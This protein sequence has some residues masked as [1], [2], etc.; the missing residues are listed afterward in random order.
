MRL[1]FWRTCRGAL[2]R[3][4]REAYMDWSW[5][6]ILSRLATYCRGKADA[7]TFPTEYDVWA[8]RQPSTKPEFRERVDRTLA[9]KR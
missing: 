1:R 3:I 5:T 9:A 8:A 2:M 4:L 7:H 6:G